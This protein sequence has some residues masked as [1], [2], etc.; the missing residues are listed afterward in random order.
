MEIATPK[1]GAM[2]SASFLD[3]GRVTAPIASTSPAPTRNVQS[4]NRAD[5]SFAAPENFTM[6]VF[7]AVLIGVLIAGEDDGENSGTIA[8]QTASEA[9]G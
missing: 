7:A 1:G 2:P 4:R 8:L 6:G 3:A 5:L 9:R